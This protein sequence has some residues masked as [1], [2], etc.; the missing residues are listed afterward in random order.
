MFVA[1]LLTTSCA[2][3]FFKKYRTPRYDITQYDKATQQA[4]VAVD[5]FLQ[6]CIQSGAPVAINRYSRIDTILLDEAAATL[7]IRLTDL[8]GFIPFRSQTTADIY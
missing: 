4:W 1:L 6:D 5:N 7:E 2:P 3:P 8:F